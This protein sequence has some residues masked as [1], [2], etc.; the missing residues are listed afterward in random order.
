MTELPP[1]TLATTTQA[2]LE[3][4]NRYR[5]T[6]SDGKEAEDESRVIEQLTYQCLLALAKG[7][8]PI[9]AEDLIVRTIIDRPDASSWHRQLLS[10]SFFKRLPAKD[11]ENLLL[12][13][14]KAIGEKLEEQSYVKIGE[15]AGTPSIVKVTT[16]KYLAQLLQD[17]QFISAEAAID[18]LL[19]LFKVA[20]HPDI[21]LATL[22]SMLSTLNSLCATELRGLVTNVLETGNPLIQKILAALDT[23]VP[24]VGSVN[25]RRPPREQEW[26]EARVD[27]SKLPEPSINPSQRPLWAALVNAAKASSALRGYF[28][29]RLLLP[30]LRISTVDHR[31]WLALF[32]KKHGAG[33]SVDKLP[34]VPLDP[35]MESDLRWN[36]T[37]LMP[38][39]LFDQADGYT[40]LILAPTANIRTFNAKLRQD[41]EK[42]NKPDVKHWLSLFDRSFN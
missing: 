5:A 42:R 28:V 12:G 32:L 34:E 9:L 1:K 20:T 39:E 16:V 2:M 38:A 24:V 25:E 21:R 11:A 31:K 6:K 26:E 13:F 4:D 19:E 22:E 36:F 37:T 23:V 29:E 41:E 14:A 10:I 27:L 30:A 40:R 17:A 3:T 15:A 8:K 18:V 33:F 7:D 35:R